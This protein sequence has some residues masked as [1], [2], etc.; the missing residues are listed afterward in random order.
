[1]I[2]SNGARN[3]IG[4]R[5]AGTLVLLCGTAMSAM[6]Q[7]E[8]AISSLI[9]ATSTTAPDGTA[10]TYGFAFELYDAETILGLGAYDGGSLTGLTGSAQVGIWDE[11]GDLLA[12]ATVPSGTGGTLAGYFSYNGIAPLT[13]QA[14][15]PYWI[16]SYDPSDPITSFRSD[17]TGPLGSASLDSDLQPI[18]GYYGEGSGLTFPGTSSGFAGAY[19]GGTFTT[20]PTPIA[21]APEP[22]SLALLISGVAGLGSLRRRKSRQ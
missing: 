20:V 12:S 13:L 18:Y 14:D 16:G 17:Y 22:A 10:G 21:G 4:R 5:I 9:P 2:L 11:N 7:P 19:L 6:A 15:T 1:M 8:P 3:M